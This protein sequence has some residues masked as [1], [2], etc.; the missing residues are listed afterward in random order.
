MYQ[1]LLKHCGYIGEL[2]IYGSFLGESETVK[3]QWK[4]S[5]V[6]VDGR[7]TGALGAHR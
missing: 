4:S 3:R 1:E 6:S 5:V 2:E 7:G